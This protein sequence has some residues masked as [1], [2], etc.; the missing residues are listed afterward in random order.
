MRKF[1]IC[2]TCLIVFATLLLV[3][4]GETIKTAVKKSDEFIYENADKVARKDEVT[5]KREINLTSVEDELKLGKQYFDQIV[6]QYE[7]KVLPKDD[8]RYIRVENIF[9]RVIAASHFRDADTPELAVIDDPMW[10]AYATTGGRT[11]FFTGLV[12]SS[13]DDEI[14]VVMGHELAHSSLSH[15]TETQWQ[16]RV[17]KAFNRKG[18]QQGF[19]ESFSAIHE[20]EADEIGLLYSTL[21]GYDPTAGRDLWAKKAA[22]RQVAYR[23]FS[24]HPA[25]AERANANALT[26]SKVS[27]YFLSGQVNPNV[28]TLL[29]C[30]NLYC[31]SGE[32]ELKGGEGGGYLALLEVA[33]NTALKNRE[34]KQER[35][36]QEARIREQQQRDAQAR[37]EQEARE[38]KALEGQPPK[39]DWHSSWAYKYQ[40]YFQRFGTQDSGV[41]F[42]LTNDA[43]AG[44]YYFIKNGQIQKGEMRFVGRGKNANSFIYEFSDP[45]GSGRIG[46]EDRGGE[47][48][49]AI[50]FPPDFKQCGGFKGARQ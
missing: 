2:K 44:N 32:D 25:D 33:I 19:A 4:C 5:G 27:E 34:A 21:A 28:E 47:V 41:S 50:C 7:G 42:A 11:I 10:N 45:F 43:R 46:F 9:K 8:A 12:N 35:E 31:R 15:I 40:G 3:G 18:V 29:A 1:L 16:S 22:S 37:A 23:Y 36:K 48:S 17:K 6:A 30:N 26:V 39:I 49:G 13:T 24:T 20:R 38:L 14:A